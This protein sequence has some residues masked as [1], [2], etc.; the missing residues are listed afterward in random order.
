MHA[1]KVFSGGDE[2]T[3][4]RLSC[5]GVR[6]DRSVIRK[7][8]IVLDGSCLDDPQPAVTSTP[9]T[10]TALFADP[11]RQ[12]RRYG[13]KGQWFTRPVHISGQQRDR[14]DGG[15]PALAGL[16]SAVSRPQPPVNGLLDALSSP[17]SATAAPHHPDNVDE[18]LRTYFP[19]T[20]MISGAG[21]TPAAP[22]ENANR[23]AATLR[24]DV[25]T[26]SGGTSSGSRSTSGRRR[27][28]TSGG[29]RRSRPS[30]TRSSSSSAS[31]G[32]LDRIYLTSNDVSADILGIFILIIRIIIIIT[33]RLSIS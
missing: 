5:C 18:L 19:L 27:S 1:V 25:S 28:R 12:R 31:N 21:G 11:H 7:P 9:A 30:S 15:D 14:D 23:D 29:G 22:L 3:A 24:P 8:P 26:A 17:S 10:T 4:R 16:A 33:R 13:I 2:A 6:M 32:S 20:L